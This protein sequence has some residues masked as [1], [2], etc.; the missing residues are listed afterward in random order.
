MPYIKITNELST[1]I[2]EL[3]NITKTTAMEL[4]KAI[5]RSNGYISNL[6][7][8]KSSQIDL[9]ELFKIFDFFKNKNDEC[10]IV[11]TQFLDKGIL[12]Y[13]SKAETREKEEF[14]RFDKQFRMIK[15]P[16]SFIDYFKS[17]LQKNSL[18]SYEIMKEVNSN[19]YIENPDRYKKK[20]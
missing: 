10:D 3:R 4:A 9:S 7:N 18:T 14:V 20:M 8:G 5:C 6:E 15:I 17:E 19:R 2:K 13:L 1:T 11:I 16:K 12:P